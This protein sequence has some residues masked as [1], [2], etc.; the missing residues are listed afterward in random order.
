MS[1]LQQIGLFLIALAANRTFSGAFRCFNNI[2]VSFFDTM[3]DIM[4]KTNH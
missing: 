4:F 3:I 1:D 2:F